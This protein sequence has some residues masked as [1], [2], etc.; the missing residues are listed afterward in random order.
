MKD[1]LQE[2]SYK[3][4]GKKYTPP[5]LQLGDFS[6][7]HWI[8]E[9]IPELFWIGIL[10]NECGFGNGSNIVS[11]IAE[12]T[13]QITADR[14]TWFAPI[15]CYKYLTDDEKSKLKQELNRIGLLNYLQKAFSNVVNYYPDFPLRFLIDSKIEIKDKKELE[16]FKSFLGIIFDRTS[17]P[18][19][20][21]QGVALD[22]I[23]RTNIDFKISSNTSLAEFPKFQEYPVT[24][25]S[26]NVAS[27]IRSTINF[28]YSN[29]H[30]SKFGNSWQ[31]YF[32][33]RG[34]QIDNCK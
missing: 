18:A 1:F 24:E 12:L 8:D 26:K 17:I 31:I 28:I 29:F 34:L 3:K 16:K 4:S 33:N 19:N 6:G 14:G 5:I 25:I 11:K 2:K 20:L 32:W 23:F 15:S 22:L 10:Q 9:L 13:S 21:I 27:S 7:V 30:E